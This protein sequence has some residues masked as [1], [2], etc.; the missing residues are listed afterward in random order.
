M[1]KIRAQKKGKSKRYRVPK[2]RCR[3]SSEYREGKGEIVDI[4]H[5]IGRPMIKVKSEKGTFFMIA[6]EGVAVGDKIEIGDR[7]DVRK[8]N[9]LPLDKIPEGTPVSNIEGVPGDNGS[10]VRSSGGFGIIISKDK[11]CIIKFPSKKVKPF[12]LKCRATIGTVA[13][14]GRPDKPI[15]KAGIKHKIMKA[16]GKLYPVTSGTAMN[17]V[18]HPFGGKTKPGI[19]K[20]VS[21]NTPPGA[22]VGSIAAKRTG[23]RK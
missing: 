14:G 20:T 2:R 16:K 12:N 23:K 4:I 3:H 18:D 10:F 5:S 8:G 1:G 17:P 11:E 22:K 19:P 9:V 6:P 21:R 15:I 7:S 13:G